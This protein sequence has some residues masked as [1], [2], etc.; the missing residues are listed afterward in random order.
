MLSDE[1]IALI[2]KIMDETQ[3]PKYQWSKFLN[4]GREEQYV[5][6]ADNFDELRTEIENIKT[7]VTLEEPPKP[8][9]V[10]Q[11][12]ATVGVLCPTCGAPATFKS[13]TA[14]TGK[15]WSG[16]FCT[17]NKEHVKWG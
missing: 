7:L 16:L 9:P 5:V 6:R 13:G 10:V 4:G 11:P 15:A 12:V 14:K 8:A 2:K 3:F 1:D 17:A